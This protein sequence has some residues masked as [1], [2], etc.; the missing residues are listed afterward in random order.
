MKTPFG[1]TPFISYSGCAEE[2]VN[3]YISFFPDS[4]IESIEYF[5]AGERGIPGKVKNIRFNLM[6]K[7][8]MAMDFMK[9]DGSDYPVP[10]WLMSLYV[11]CADDLMFN[12]IFINFAREG[13]VL[14]GPEPHENFR[15]AAW[16]TD[17]Y[18]I[19]WQLV[20]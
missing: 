8:F 1:I 9:V 10:S 18:G 2:A 20:C 12:N 6:D 15:Q 17:K 5:K 19:T 3:F 16:V 13:N 14:M 4:R 11:D 7:P